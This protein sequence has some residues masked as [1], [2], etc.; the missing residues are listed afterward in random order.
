VTRRFLSTMTWLAIGHAAIGLLFWVF[1]QVPES[2]VFMLATSLLL[3][4]AMIFL[5]G[6]VEAFGLARAQLEMRLLPAVGLAARRVPLVVAPLVLFALIFWLT[7]NAGD[8]LSGHSGEID[9]WVIARTGWTRTA[10]LHAALEWLLAFVRYGI[11][12]SL[13]VT[14][15]A[16]VVVRGVRSVGRAV[17]LQRAFGWRQLLVTAASVFVGVWLPGQVVYWRP[18]SLPPTW[19]EPAFAAVKLAVLFLIFNAAWTVVLWTAACEARR[20]KG[21]STP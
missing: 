4:V 10:G 11:G 14:L 6:C 15:F 9:A 7:A 5:L 13:A 20:E 12:L 17:W 3:V 19:V 21:Y 16:A 1:L 18:T 8:W 2:N